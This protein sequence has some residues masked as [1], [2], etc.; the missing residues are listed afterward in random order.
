MKYGFDYAAGESWGR[1]R[2]LFRQALVVK[3]AGGLAAGVVLVAIAPKADAIFGGTDLTIPFLV[4]ALLAAAAVPGRSRRA[5]RSSS[6]SAMTC[7]PGCWR[8]RWG[9]G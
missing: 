3:A 9:C 4:A 6:A 1:L 7:E 8:C 2:R 5:P